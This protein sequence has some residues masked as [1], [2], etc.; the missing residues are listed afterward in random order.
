[1]ISIKL[2]KILMTRASSSLAPSSSSAGSN[3]GR[4]NRDR[5]GYSAAP[6]GV[7]VTLL[8]DSASWMPHRDLVDTMGLQNNF[9]CLGQVSFMSLRSCLQSINL[10][11][12]VPY[13]SFL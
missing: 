12:N 8:T 7:V 4:D 1:M 11:I 3:Q 13:N 9:L 2:A 10:L 6:V 5:E